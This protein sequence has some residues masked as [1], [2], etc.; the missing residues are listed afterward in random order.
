MSKQPTSAAAAAENERNERNERNELWRKELTSQAK[1]L[2]DGK[3]L[4]KDDLLLVLELMQRRTL[5]KQVRQHLQQ[6]NEKELLLLSDLGLLSE[7]EL[8]DPYLSALENLNEKGLMLLK[9][10]CQL[11]PEHLKQ[12]DLELLGELLP[13]LSADAMYFC[14]ACDEPV[15]AQDALICDDYDCMCLHHG[16]GKNVLYS[17]E[18]RC[19]RVLTAGPHAASAAEQPADPEL[20]QMLIKLDLEKLK[21]NA[22]ST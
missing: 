16:N 10:L 17:A 2:L 14:E 7:E 8:L 6:L 3:F 20:E 15:H 5:L 1:V 11:D 12:L 13:Q 9:E 22:T 19:S 18:L 4:E 21:L